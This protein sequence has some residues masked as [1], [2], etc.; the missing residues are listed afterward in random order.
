MRT[1]LIIFGV[2]FLVI[3][4]FLFFVPVQEVS[5]DTT[6]GSDVRTS[7]ALVTVPIGWSYA[8]LI[9]GFV[10]LVFG[11]AIPGPK[12]VQGPRG[13]RGLRGKGPVHHKRAKKHSVPRR[14]SR[15]ASLP[16]GTSV[17]TTTR[18]RR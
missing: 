16:R 10:L 9:I 7:S 18:I 15:R 6:S 17:T 13:A 12:A 3:G 8:S 11:L 4:G 2:I 1:G 14:K 5:V